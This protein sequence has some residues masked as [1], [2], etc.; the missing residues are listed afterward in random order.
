MRNNA[1]KQREESD[2]IMAE[3]DRE[4]DLKDEDI[5]SGRDELEAVLREDLSSLRELAEAGVRGT[6]RAS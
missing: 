5:A 2:E 4:M 6:S 3:L 1:Q